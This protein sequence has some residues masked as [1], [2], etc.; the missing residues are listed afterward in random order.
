MEG[1]G[2][3]LHFISIAAFYDLDVNLSGKRKGPS[4]SSWSSLLAVL[5]KLGGLCMVCV[6]RGVAGQLA[7]ATHRRRHLQCTSPTLV[8]LL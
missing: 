4:F 8:N 7:A 2:R 3:L 6:E 1:V 5:A